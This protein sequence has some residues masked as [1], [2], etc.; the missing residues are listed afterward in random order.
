MQIASNSRWKLEIR[1]KTNMY[2]D[3][4]QRG[5]LTAERSMRKMKE[6]QKNYTNLRL[7]C[8]HN[9]YGAWGGVMVKA[10]RY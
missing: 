4:T 9:V 10:L 3:V 5:S 6:E 2:S 8:I 1:H 7:Y